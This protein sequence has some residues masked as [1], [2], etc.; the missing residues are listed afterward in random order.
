[1]PDLLATKW[2]RLATFFLLYMTEGFPQGFAA[3]AVATEMR[4]MSVG[5]KVINAFVAVITL[6]WAFKWVVGPVVDVFYSD[7]LGRRRGWIVAMQVM[8]IVTLM[9]AMPINFNTE[10]KLFTLMLVLHNIFAATQ[11]V[12]IDA[13]ACG[14]LKEDERGLANGLMFAGAHSGNIVGGA[15]VLFLTHYIPFNI[16]FAFVSACI[17]TITLL[18]SLHLREPREKQPAAAS[19]TSRMARV[20]EEIRKYVVEVFSAMFGSR[21]AFVGMIFALL[22][23]G[24]FALAS[25]FSSTLPKELYHSNTEIAKLVAISGLVW[26]V[27]CVIGGFLSDRFGR[28]RVFA[29]YVIATIFPTLWLAEAM[30]R[31]GWI[32]PVNLDLPNRPI[33]SAHL[34]YV[35][36]GASL[37]Y[38]VFNGLMYGTRTAI[39]MDITTPAV[40]ATQFT[41]Y[42]A[43]LNVTMSYSY[44][45]Q[46]FA[47]ESW[48]YPI[49]L[50]IDSAVGLFCILL[51]PLMARRAC[52]G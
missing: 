39:F 7:R 42:M 20:W 44:A 13:F 35:F 23:S 14:V 26:V 18:V 30:F 46:G 32:L 36:W 31:C 19:G 40:A 17:L 24:A 52:N 51:L 48:G 11:D 33:P 10:I 49:M 12:A 34:I 1:M 6:P 41:A 45:W 50:V 16:T 28:R 5:P 27:A 37:A 47:A 29:L 2:S 43:L 9:A 8:M 22:P 3:V 38:C 25:P 15:G 21:A 4:S